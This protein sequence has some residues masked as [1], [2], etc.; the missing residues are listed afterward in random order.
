MKATQKETGNQNSPMSIKEM[1]FV[2]KNFPKEKT[3]GQ[4]GFIGKF[5]QIQMERI[6]ESLEYYTTT[7]YYTNTRISSRK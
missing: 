1:E 4:T 7:V 3:L 6:L 5:Y 2:V